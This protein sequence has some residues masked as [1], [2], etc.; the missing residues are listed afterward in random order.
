MIILKDEGMIKMAEKKTN[1]FTQWWF[2]LIAVLLVAGIAFGVSYFTSQD[3]NDDERATKKKDKEESDNP[4]AGKWYFVSEG[5]VAYI[6]FYENGECMMSNDDVEF[7][8]CS[9]EYDDEELTLKN[10]GYGSTFKYDMGD[11]YF[12]I[13]TD[14]FYAK[15]YKAEKEAEEE[16]RKKDD[17]IYIDYS[18]SSN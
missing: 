16:R 8:D 10:D 1:L 17:D 2:W 7:D 3:K 6:E 18:G 14:T 12:K 4:F 15:R 13:G 11:G 5:E 9:Y